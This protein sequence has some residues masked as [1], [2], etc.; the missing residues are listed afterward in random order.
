M[1]QEKGWKVTQ[2]IL[3]LSAELLKM[4]GDDLDTTSILEHDH[5]TE[6]ELLLEIV[7]DNMRKETQ[8]FQKKSPKGKKDK[9]REWITKINELNSYIQVEGYY[10]ESKEKEG[11]LRRLNEEFLEDQA[12][13][14]KNTALL[15]DCKPT[16]EFLP[17]N[18]GKGDIAI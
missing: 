2:Q 10:R 6:D 3:L 4:E 17:W 18:K 15:N 1:E 16:K 13:I 9:W 14:F 5:E 7:L 12:A 8:Y 11:E